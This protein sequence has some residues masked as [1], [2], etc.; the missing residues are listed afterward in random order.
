MKKAFSFVLIMLFSLVLHAQQG[1]ELRC[2]ISVESSKIQGTN[3]RVFQTLQTALY[4]FMNNRVWTTHTYSQNEKIECNIMVV[5]S[6]VTGD[7]YKASITVQSTRPV[8]GSSYKTTLLNYV[9]NNFSFTY[10]EYQTLEFNET[11]YLSNLTS[12][13][14]FYAYIILGI[15]YDTFSS[16]GGTDFFKKAETIS[17]NASSSSDDGWKP[18]IKS[19]K[20]R[21]WL[22]KNIMDKNYQPCREFM[23]KYHR[24]G[25]D[26]MSKK[27]AEAR[28]EIA[29]SIDLLKKVFQ[30]K[31]DP[32][33]FLL[34]VIFDAK[35]D[36]F[37]NVF[38]EGM[39]EEKSRVYNML[40][41]INATNATKYEK[42]MKQQSG[43]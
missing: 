18:F 21:Y 32:F 28:I 17:N 8:W 24:L 38:S 13:M 35:A 6:E 33:L 43:S 25:L 26:N 41:E 31:P 27:Q 10:T 9:D 39:P 3:K 23:Y 19:N 4:E 14:A 37:A 11:Q 1:G 40:M 16:E 20:N 12:T 34:Q 29:N 30:S 15:D 7:E 22:I 36:E 5:I 42:I 2:N